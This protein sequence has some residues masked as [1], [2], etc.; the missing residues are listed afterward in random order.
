MKLARAISSGARYGSPRLVSMKDSTPSRISARVRS[1]AVAAVDD[2]E[3]PVHPAH[4]HVR[5]PDQHTRP[6]PHHEPTGRTDVR[7]AD[8]GP[9]GDNHDSD[10]QN[11]GAG[12]HHRDGAVREHLILHDAQTSRG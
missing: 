2:D 12:D 6:E 4:V 7:I 8:A 10:H 11:H 1:L 3:I 9:Q 5:R